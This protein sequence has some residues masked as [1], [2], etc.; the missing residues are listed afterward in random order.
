MPEYFPQH[1]DLIRSP[2]GFSLTDKA[3][4]Y[5]RI[6]LQVKLQFTVQCMY[7]LNTEQ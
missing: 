7:I 3:S 5:T 6:Q 4:F 2:Y 1:S